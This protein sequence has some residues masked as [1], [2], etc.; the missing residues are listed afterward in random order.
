MI[1]TVVTALT[2]S[3]VVFIIL[4]VGIQ[5]ERRRGRR[6]FADSSR[7]W[8]DKRVEGLERG[9]VDKCRHFI[10]YI[11]QLHWYYSIHSLL[12]T[13][14]HVITAFYAY[15]EKVFERNRSRT[16]KLRAEKRKIGETSHLGQVA[17]HKE[18]TALTSVQKTK[19]RHKKLEEKH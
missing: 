19:L 4:L 12:R 5:K 7:S 3:I 2:I 6:Y 16:K 15:F 9:I 8:L 14:L 1:S 10:K 17:E 18:E 11:V 13:V